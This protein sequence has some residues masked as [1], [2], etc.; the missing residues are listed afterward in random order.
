MEIFDKQEARYSQNKTYRLVSLLS[1]ALIDL[2][3]IELDDIGN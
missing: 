1:I 3:I 2:G